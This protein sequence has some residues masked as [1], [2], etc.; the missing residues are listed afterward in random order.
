MVRNERCMR[1]FV[2]D[3]INGRLG[4]SFRNRLRM[5]GWLDLVRN[6]ARPAQ[7]R[8]K[9]R[10]IKELVKIIDRIIAND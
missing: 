8:I 5:L 4:S 1:A 3:Y 10:Y 6:F 9:P 2:V 7:W